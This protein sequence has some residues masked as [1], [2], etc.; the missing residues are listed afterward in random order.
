L[1]TVSTWCGRAGVFNRQPSR[2]RGVSLP[3]LLIS[4]AIAACLLTAVASAFV[5]SASAVES[6]DR[7]LRSAQS[8]RVSMGVLIRD[9]RQSDAC[10]VGTAAEQSQAKITADRL[11]VLTTDGKLIQYR[12]LA[13]NRQLTMQIDGGDAYVLARNVEHA[14][15]VGELEGDAST[16]ERRTTRVTV[17]LTITTEG[18]PLRLDA[19]ATPRRAMAL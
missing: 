11:D 13:A 19:S 2:R 5:A 15:F 6:N 10:Q 18:Q 4:I 16:G 1:I 3:E 9:I 17:K 7:Y 12:Y 14:R 8:A